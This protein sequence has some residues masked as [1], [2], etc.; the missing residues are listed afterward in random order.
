MRKLGLNQP[1]VALLKILPG[2]RPTKGLVGHYRVV[3][4][5]PSRERLVQGTVS[6]AVKAGR[7]FEAYH[8]MA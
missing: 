6:Q 8:D 4:P 3:N 7:M 5:L 2:V 1:P